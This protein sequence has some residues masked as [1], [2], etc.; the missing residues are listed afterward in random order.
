MA[1]K[2]ELIDLAKG[3]GVK[4]ESVLKVFESKEFVVES[5]TYEEE[6]AKITLIRC[7][8][9]EPQK[10]VLTSELP[11]SLHPYHT[12]PQDIKEIETPIKI[13]LEANIVKPSGSPYYVPLTLAMK[14]DVDK[15]T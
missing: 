3:L 9:L 8:R 13:F 5:P 7:I 4:V 10:V 12:S 11:V 14:K 2:Q 6:F 15:K 1:R